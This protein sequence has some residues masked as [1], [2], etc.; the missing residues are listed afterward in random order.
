M[1]FLGYKIWDFITWFRRDVYIEN[2][3]ESVQDH[4]V[5]I[6]ANGKLYKQ[7]ATTG[8]IDGVQILTTSGGHAIANGTATF[9]FSPGEGLD[10]T[11]SLGTIN[12]SA[13]DATTSNKGVASFDSSD[14][15]VSSG[16]VSLNKR[17]VLLG[18]TYFH[19]NT[20][21][22][23]I[24][25]WGSD[26]ESTSAQYF[27]R[28]YMP[29][30]GRVIKIISATDVTTSRSITIKMY[31]NG[32]GS[33]TGTTLTQDSSNGTFNAS[34]AGDWSFSAGDFLY[35]KR[36]EGTSSGGPNACNMVIEVEYNH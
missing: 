15:T 21:A 22:V 35:F 26:A 17:T 19:T 25:A 1:G 13:E 32:T 16:A 2:I 23:F 34:V 8:D 11:N 28:W 31:R 5:G 24:P 6:D 36:D 12:F 18:S 29:Y 3:T 4:V 20:A 10:I 30:A 27:H 33:Q 14:F 7:D 9:T